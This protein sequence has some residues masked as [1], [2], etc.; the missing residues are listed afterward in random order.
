M[1]D[2]NKIIVNSGFGAVG[3]APY[4]VLYDDRN[5]LKNWLLMNYHG[6]MSYMERSVDIRHDLRHLFA[7]VRSVIVTL[8][9]IKRVARHTPTIAAFAHNFPDYHVEI[10]NR[11]HSLLSELQ[12]ADQT[13]RG[14][15]VVDSAPAFERAWAV[16][17]GLGWIGRNSMLIHPELG[18]YTLIGLLLI[19]RE[20]DGE[21]PVVVE[22]RCPDGCELCRR[23][24][25][26]SAISDDRTIDA[27]R[28]VSYMTCE[29]AEIN[30]PLHSHLLGCDR[31]TDVCPFNRA[32]PI[33]EP[34]VT[35]DWDGLSEEEF[36]ERFCHSSFER[37][38]FEK[39]RRILAVHDEE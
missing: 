11:L 17:A 39:I 25:P 3:T 29:R 12:K 15:A 30:Y 27:R 9:P 35:V 33:M 10:K 16:R 6:S 5:R 4:E 8:T 22:N 24:C 23:S 32:V 36:V 37:V 20:I 7:D 13:I 31:C 19:N 18:S 28:C 34:T 26:N 2:L 1:S 14:R 21:M 38:G